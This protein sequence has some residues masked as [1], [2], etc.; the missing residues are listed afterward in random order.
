MRLK[1]Y[2]LRLK[3]SFE[4]TQ[5]MKTKKAKAILLALLAASLAITSCEQHPTDTVSGSNNW[6]IYRQF[7]ST[8]P[9]G[10]KWLYYIRDNSQHGWALYT[11]EEYKVGGKLEVVYTPP[12]SKTPESE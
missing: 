11:D 4:E 12:K 1:S 10:G 6:V 7:E 3:N 8:Q 2:I 9:Q 5:T